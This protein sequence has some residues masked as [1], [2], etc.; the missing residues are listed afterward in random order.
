LEYEKSFESLLGK[1]KVS[2]EDKQIRDE[3]I[4]HKMMMEQE[5]K[6]KYEQDK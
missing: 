1:S 4:K 6:A 5:A 3:A 2:E